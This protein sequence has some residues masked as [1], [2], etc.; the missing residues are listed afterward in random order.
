MTRARN[1]RLNNIGVIGLIVYACVA[2]HLWQRPAPPQSMVS[3]FFDGGYLEPAAMVD[4]SS[5]KVEGQ[6]AVTSHRSVHPLFGME[7]EP[8]LGDLASKWHAVQF[9]IGY[10]QKV[11]ADCRAQK[12]CPEPARDL[13]NIIAEGSGRTCRARVGLINRAVDLAITPTAD[14]AQ[15]GGRGPLELSLRDPTNPSRRLRRLCDRQVCR[16]ARGRFI[17]C[18]RKNRHLAEPRSERIPRGGC[19]AGEWRMADSGQS[20][21]HVGAGYRYAE[22]DP[23]IPA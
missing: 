8:A 22:S 23:K 21:S 10:E 19:G 1:E 5:P 15:M 4:A 3:R 16:I 6:T 2:G 18:R 14:E 11:L 20:P 13:L 9:E 12:P 7:T 17:R